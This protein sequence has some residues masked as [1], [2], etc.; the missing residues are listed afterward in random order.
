ML[1]VIQGSTLFKRYRALHFLNDG[2]KK[3][4]NVTLRKKAQDLAAEEES[5]EQL[6]RSTVTGKLHGLLS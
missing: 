1:L 5:M 6:L 3:N 2:K 4:A